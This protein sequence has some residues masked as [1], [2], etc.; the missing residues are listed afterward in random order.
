MP[1]S[2]ASVDDFV[3]GG[4]GGG[5]PRSGSTDTELAARAIMREAREARTDLTAFYSFVMRH[6]LTKERLA[7]APHQRLMFSFLEAH[8]LC[9]LRMPV[10]TGK[11]FGMAAAALFFLGNDVTQRAAIISKTQGQ[12]KKPLSMVA[13]YIIEPSLNAGLALVF[14]WLVPSRRAKDPWTQSELFI[15]RPPGIRDPSLMAAGLDAATPGSRWGFFVAD[16]L[17]DDENT[18]TPQARAKVESR[19]NGRLFSRLDPGTGRGVVTN[20]PWDRDDLTYYLEN[21]AGWPTLTMDIYGFI[22]VTGVKAA[23]MKQA[24]REHVRPS[25][26]RQGGAFQ[27]YRLK[28]HDPD[29]AEQTPLWPARYSSEQIH[30]LRYGE[31]GRGGML[32]REFARLFLCQPL[33]ADT[34]RCQH[35][36]VEK[37]KKRGLGTRL[38]EE[39]SGPNKTYCGLDIGIGPGKQHDR[40]VFFVIEVLD[41]GSRRLIDVESGRWPGYVIVDKLLSKADKYGAKLRVENVGAQEFIRQFAGRDRKDLL[42]DAHTTSGAGKMNKWDLDYGVESIFS[43]LQNGAWIIPCDDDGVCHPEVQMWIDD[44]LYYQPPPSHTGN[45]LIASWICREAARKGGRGG[46]KPRVGRRRDF[47]KMGG[48]Y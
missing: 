8:P 20:T 46:S 33:D 16:D 27:W 3:G 34:A 48:G 18:M 39:Y 13:D 15:E 47:V 21:L 29:P 45:H 11:T 12:A 17:I 2:A 42:I 9:V 1:R 19:F 26:T 10:G 32:P 30:K 41:D 44:M 23:W 25:F 6:E 36:W 7:A 43:E 31:E 22:R 24:L 4:S 38:L 40:T 5:G 14:P 37:C 28:A 35:D